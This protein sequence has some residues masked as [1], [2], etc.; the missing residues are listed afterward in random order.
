MDIFILDVYIL[1][2]K[3][4]DPVDFVGGQRSSEMTRGHRLKNLFN[5]VFQVRREGWIFVI[6]DSVEEA[7]YF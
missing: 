7:C 1:L 6:L 2:A 5:T 4:E 3:K